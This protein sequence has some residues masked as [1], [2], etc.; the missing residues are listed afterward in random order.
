[1]F[2][3]GNPITFCNLSHG[4]LCFKNEKINSSPEDLKAGCDIS[5]LIGFVY[6][7]SVLYFRVVSDVQLF[8]SLL[9]HLF[10]AAFMLEESFCLS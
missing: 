1:M 10:L 6:D 3:Q 4:D 5:L 2:L 7:Q 8:A 9:C